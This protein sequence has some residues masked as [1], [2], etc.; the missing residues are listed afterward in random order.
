MSL[1][2]VGINFHF[3]RSCNFNCR[4]CY[5]TKNKSPLLSLQ[6]Q[7]FI[8]RS[9]KEEGAEKIN[10]AGGEPFLYPKRLGELVKAA[11]E[12]GYNS[13]SIISNG[14]MVKKDWLLNYGKYIDI[15]GVSVDSVNPIT[16]YIH[17]RVPIGCVRP[18]SIIDKIYMIDEVCKRMN[19][20]FKVNTVVSKINKDELLSPFINCLTVKRWKVFQLLEIKNENGGKL[21]G[22]KVSNEEYQNYIQRNRKLLPNPNIMVPENND[23]I[24][25]S[26]VI[27]D[28]KGRLLDNS[29]GKYIPTPSILDIG[30]KAAVK[31]LGKGFIKEKFIKRGGIY[32]WS[33]RQQK[34]LI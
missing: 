2:K 13:V 26:Y 27:I 29:T 19:I 30:I 18:V 7:I 32:N 4:F 10:F 24:K 8:L 15:M 23:A 16:N 9:A 6:Q 3:T 14:S 1:D 5:F 28:E 33:K 31:K 21:H 25:S 34:N 11:K 12:M 17:G 20:I 22:L